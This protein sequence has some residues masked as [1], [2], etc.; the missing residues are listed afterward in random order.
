MFDA[1][2]KTPS[3]TFDA[4][5]EFPSHDEHD[6]IPKGCDTMDVACFDNICLGIDG[7]LICTIHPSA[8]KCA[9]LEMGGRLFYCFC[10]EKFSMVL[11]AGCDHLCRFRWAHIRHMGITSNYLSFETFQLEKENDKILNVGN[12]MVGHNARV[13][14]DWMATPIPVHWIMETDDAY[15]FLHFKFESKWRELI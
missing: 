9:E 15:N 3:M 1:D 11:M 14:T 8:A 2:N 13:E 4:G 5:R 6:E 12:T 10:K 7:M